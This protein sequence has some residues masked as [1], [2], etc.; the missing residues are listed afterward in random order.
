MEEKLHVEIRMD[1]RRV[2][3]RLDGDGL[4]LIAAALR[5][6][7]MFYTAFERWKRRHL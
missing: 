1:G 4:S 2:V 3:T 7:N 6:V 5:C